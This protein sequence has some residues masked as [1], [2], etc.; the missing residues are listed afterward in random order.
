VVVGALLSTLALTVL[1]RGNRPAFSFSLAATACIA[2][3]LV[4]FFLYAYPANQQ[5]E[6]WS[7]LPENW[8]ELRR[9]WEISHAVGAV[10]NL[11]ALATLTLSL[12][13][14]KRG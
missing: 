8:E 4:V 9:Q 10:L 2:L 13:T 11:V 7:M 1:E 3:S 6:N 12:L 5:T 14:G